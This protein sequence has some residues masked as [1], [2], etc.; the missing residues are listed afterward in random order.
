M[1]MYGLSNLSETFGGKIRGLK[2]PVKFD[3]DEVSTKITEPSSPFRDSSLSLKGKGF[4]DSLKSIKGDNKFGSSLSFS[5]GRGF[6]DTVMSLRGKGLGGG[7]GSSLS[8]SKGKGF[9]NT[10]MSLRGTKYNALNNIS[11]TGIE[12]KIF[13]S[14]RQ[15]NFQNPMRLGTQTRGITKQYTGFEQALYGNRIGRGQVFSDFIAK[16]KT[17]ETPVGEL[18]VISRLSPVTGAQILP[19][20]SNAPDTWQQGS[21]ETYG[22][23]YSTP[24]VIQTAE[25]LGSAG[26]GARDYLVSGAK[27][28]AQGTGTVL[29]GLGTGIAAVGKGFGTGIREFAEATGAVETKEEREARR[30][31]QTDM[32]KYNLIIREQMLRQQQGQG[33]MPSKG[34]GGQLPGGYQTGFLPP[35]AGFPDARGFPGGN[36]YPDGR[37]PPTGYGGGFNTISPSTMPTGFGM[38]GYKSPTQ[39][40]TEGYGLG[41]GGVS[42]ENI[43]FAS[44]ITG[45]RDENLAYA[46]FLPQSEPYANKVMM[47]LGA[48]RQVSPYSDVVGESLG[49]IGTGGNASFVDKIRYVFGTG[50]KQQ[51]EQRQVL[52]PQPI[53]QVKR[54]KV[55]KQPSQFYSYDQLPGGQTYLRASVPK[56]TPALS[57]PIPPSQAELQ[58]QAQLRQA[59][60]EQAQMRQLQYQQ[61]QTQYP[62]QSI[63]QQ[64]P[65]MNQQIPQNKF[66][67]VSPGVDIYTPQPKRVPTQKAGYEPGKVWS[68][69]SKKYVQYE[70]DSY[71]TRR[72]YMGQSQQMPQGY[73]SQEQTPYLPQ[74]PNSMLPSY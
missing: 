46:S 18:Q 31:Y 29:T 15:N 62:Q 38:M 40:V 22:E 73:I 35:P 7:F 27:S 45:V 10:V 57:A 53:Q 67:N 37:Y 63:S 11:S 47:S 68:P 65:Y 26:A 28:L 8:F 54:S 36:I 12:N 43:R 3:V 64:T 41:G 72:K 70:R 55:T 2:E 60:I 34:F 52:L 16:N 4:D 66:Q 42:P 48:R 30:K 17:V 58:Q 49:G 13:G 50:T 19:E 61:S 51:N 69:K 39:R 14:I 74:G 6:E 59:L 25:Q 5:T 20:I 56:P 24:S 32:A 23:N 33:G 1:S 21:F 71:E 9:E 44:K